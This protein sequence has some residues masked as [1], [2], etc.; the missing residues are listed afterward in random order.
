MGPDASRNIAGDFP[1][2]GQLERELADFKGT[3]AALVFS[4]GYAAN[5]G[6]IP[7]LVGKGDEIFS[8]QL[9]HGSLIDGC[10][11]SRAHT[12]VYKHCDVADL[13]QKLAECEAENKLVMT[14]AVFSMDG[15]VAPLYADRRRARAPWRHVSRR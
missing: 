15:D 2:H 9:N 10:R 6:V 13:E 1:V 4:S 3:E 8:D 12:T 7:V 11:L 5:V 14:D